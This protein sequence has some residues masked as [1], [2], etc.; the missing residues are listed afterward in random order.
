MKDLNAC[1][2]LFR[3]AVFFPGWLSY[4]IKGFKLIKLKQLS[5]GNIVTYPESLI[6]KN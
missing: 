6:L 2:T 5:H 1:K 3:I 4:L